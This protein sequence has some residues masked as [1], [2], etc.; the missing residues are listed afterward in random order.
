MLRSK[1]HQGGH[2]IIFFTNMCASFWS[3]FRSKLRHGG[4]LGYWLK[5]KQLANLII[6]MFQSKL[7]N[8]GHLGYWKKKTKIEKIIE[9]T[10]YVAIFV[11]PD[12]SC[13]IISIPYKMLSK[14]PNGC[15]SI[16]QI[17]KR[18]LVIILVLVTC[19]HRM[20]HVLII[21]LFSAQSVGDG[22]KY[23]QPCYLRLQWRKE[24]GQFYNL[25]FLLTINQLKCLFSSKRWSHF[26]M[27]NLT[28]RCLMYC[29][30][31]DGHNFVVYFTQG[32]IFTFI[33]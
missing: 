19:I 1:L 17:T 15:N 3:T 14:L 6:L 23:L 9:V 32:S 29:F 13:R 16:Y 20:Q 12:H 24:L 27:Y 18:L 4:L 2:H 11:V 8:G 21:S 26:D 30:M 7:R 5:K 22:R 25:C 10:I 33:S 31:L 28:Y